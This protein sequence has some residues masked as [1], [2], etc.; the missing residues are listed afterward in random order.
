VARVL[1]GS[2]ERVYSQRYG[3]LRTGHAKVR[4]AGNGASS[5]RFCPTTGT[6]A[7]ATC[8]V[9]GAYGDDTLYGDDGQDVVYGQDGNDTIA[10]GAG[11]DDLYG[12]LGADTIN[13][14]D[15]EDAIL[16][17]R[18]GVQDRYENGDR[19]VTSTLNQPPA[20]TFVSRQP[21]SV[22]READLLH[23]VNG[24]DF[25]GG[26]SST[27]MPLDGISYGGADRIRGGDGN[28]SIHAGAGDDL[29]N[30][31]TGGD[32][33]F[34]DRGNDVMWG[35]QGRACAPTET[36][37]LADPGAHGEYIDHLV[38]GKGADVIDWRPRGVYG[39]GPTFA[40]RTCSTSTT[41]VTTKKDGTTDPCSWFEMTGRDND[42]TDASTFADNQHHQGVDWIYGGWDRDVMQ[43]DLADNGPNPGDRLID[44][45][46]VYNLYSHCNAA[47][48]GFNDVRIP[49]PAVVS[50]LQEWATGIGAGR[51]GPGTPDVLTA[52]T[53][54]YDELALVYTGDDKAHG[55][56]SAYPTTP[57]HFDDANACSGF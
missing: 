3:T 37:C 12:E 45:F 23:D 5:T 4:V 52:G 19:S 56:G 30:G 34:G 28:D 41:P 57:G 36:T 16:G 14:N 43:A 10:G 7:T 8:E 25:V 39:T 21:G 44:W 46:G 33:V 38:G 11:D 49:A 18:G 9:S 50:F 53:S 40:D 51:P 17:D 2:T 13:G 22:S 29:V 20:L 1:D 47:Y 24:T 54:A 15:G 32:V 31:D 27:P 48:G 42:T 6:D 35:G 55:T 26:A